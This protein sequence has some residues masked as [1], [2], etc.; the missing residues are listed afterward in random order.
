M[1]GGENRMTNKPKAGGKRMDDNMSNAQWNEFLE[2]LAKLIEA[3]ATTPAEA[4]QIVRDA[5]AK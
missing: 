5:K 1:S 4:A 2:T 3:K